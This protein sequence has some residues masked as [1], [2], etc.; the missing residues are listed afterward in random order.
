M[1]RWPCCAP[2]LPVSTRV[3]PSSRWL[4][5]TSTGPRKLVVTNDTPKSEYDRRQAILL[6]ARADVVAS[7]ADVRQIRA[8]LGLPAETDEQDLGQVPPDLNQTFSSVAPGAGGS[9]SERSSTRRHPF[10]RR[11]AP[12]HGRGVREGRRRQYHLCSGWRPDAPGHQ[13]GRSQAR[14]RQ[15]RSRSGRSSICATA[16]F[17]AEIDGVVTR[18]NVNPGDNV[19]VGQA[20]HGDPIARRD[21]G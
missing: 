7:L 8:S 13:A 3:K 19:Q 5:S 12:S 4:R 10:I 6:S 9:H 20:L 17:V 16:M 21:L 11:G 14:G 18:R 1:T 15:A 2:R